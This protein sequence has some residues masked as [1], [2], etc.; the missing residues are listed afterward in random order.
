MQEILRGLCNSSSNQAVV[1]YPTSKWITGNKESSCQ[2]RW[3]MIA[4]KDNAALKIFLKAKT[5]VAR[6]NLS[7]WM[8][9]TAGK[10]QLCKD[11]IRWQ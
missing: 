2:L 6:L 5:N 3:G 11:A 4:K 9:F 7:L 10:T 1:M 8:S